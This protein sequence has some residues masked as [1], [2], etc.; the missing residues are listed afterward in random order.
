MGDYGGG[1]GGGGGH[2]GHGGT[3]YKIYVVRHIFPP[4]RFLLAAAA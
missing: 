3:T 4:N 1:G 2:G